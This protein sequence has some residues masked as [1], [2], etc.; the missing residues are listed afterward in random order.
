[1]DRIAAPVIA[2][3]VL[4]LASPAVAGPKGKV[5][6]SCSQPDATVTIGDVYSGPVA[7]IPRKLPV[8]DHEATFEASGFVA[9]TVAI[10]VLKKGT[11]ELV[12]EL[13]PVPPP[14][15]MTI[16]PTPLEGR[17]CNRYGMSLAVAQQADPPMVILPVGAVVE[18]LEERRTCKRVRVVESR[19]AVALGQESWVYAPNLGPVPDDGAPPA[20][21]TT[22]VRVT[23]GAPVCHSIGDEYRHVS[24]FGDCVG[25]LG[26]G[27]ELD[28]LAEDLSGDGS[29]LRVDTLMRSGSYLTGLIE[30][31]RVEVVADGD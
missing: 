4:L 25:V 1:M 22:R 23:R 2:S 19:N 31:G 6:I 20:P 21:A 12:V 7:D 29:Y 26:A 16:E 13:E 9:T 11:A 15:W 8:G 10:S 17:S 28:V 24:R 14:R 30:R 5:A 3:L 27:T 18:E